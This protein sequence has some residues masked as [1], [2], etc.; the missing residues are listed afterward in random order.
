MYTKTI[1]GSC[2]LIIAMSAATFAASMDDDAATVCQNQKWLGTYTQPINLG[3]QIFA[4]S[5]QFSAGGTV[6]FAGTYYPEGMLASG[7]S[8]SAFGTWQCLKDGMVAATIVF[9]SYRPDGNGDLTLYYHVRAT[10]KGQIVDGNT[11]KR[12]LLATRLYFSGQ[13]P[14]NPEDGYFWDLTDSQ[15]DFTRLK[16]TFAD[17]GQ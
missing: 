2:L 3:G 11:I 8:T 4:E 16:V 12:T 6:T 10:F 1:L 15:V 7:T 14:S 13:D 5:L 9:A 17:L